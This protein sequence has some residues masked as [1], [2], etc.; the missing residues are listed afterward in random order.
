MT[1]ITEEQNVPRQS[2]EN[3]GGKSSPRV[4]D[5]MSGDLNWICDNFVCFFSNERRS[6][7]EEKRRF[8]CRILF[9]GLSEPKTD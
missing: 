4:D 7:R 2:A 5:E 8:V 6:K 1:S 9:P 3:I